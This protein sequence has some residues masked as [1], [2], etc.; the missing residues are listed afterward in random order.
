MLGVD[1]LKQVFVPARRLKKDLPTPWSGRGRMVRGI[2]LEVKPP[3]EIMSVKHLAACAE[4]AK[5]PPF[6]EEE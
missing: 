2:V 6:M 1:G 5:V 3:L 4:I